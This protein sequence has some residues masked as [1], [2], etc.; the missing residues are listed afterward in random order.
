M[1]VHASLGD[2][3]LEPAPIRPEW[4]LHGQPVARSRELSRAPD[5]TAMTL[6]WD[7]TPGA[8]RWFF[9]GD[10]TVHILEGEVVVEDGEGVRTLRA[11]DVALF[12]AGTWATW[13]VTR[14]LRKVAFCRDPM[15]R[16]VLKFVQAVRALKQRL[17]GGRSAPAFGLAASA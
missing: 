7:C 4:I 16:P 6:L 15:P 5:G 13:T 2:V 14:H 17:K 10:E 1:I 8:F 3:S 9:G 11:G 12:P